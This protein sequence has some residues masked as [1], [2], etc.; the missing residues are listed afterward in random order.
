MPPTIIFGD[1]RGLDLEEIKPILQKYNIKRLDSAAG[2]QKG[3]SER[4]L[5]DSGWSKEFLI[6]TKILSGPLHSGTLTPE[7]VEESSKQSLERLKLEKVNV[8]YCHSADLK[9][10]LEDQARGFNNVYKKGRFEAVS[11]RRNCAAWQA[12]KA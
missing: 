11:A 8:L 1:I 4:S 2:Y 3:E 6:D 5:G 7:K 9:T 12:D 10:P